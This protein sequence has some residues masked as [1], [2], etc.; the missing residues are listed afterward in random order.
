VSSFPDDSILCR[1]VVMVGVDGVT[2][3]T[4][5][6]DLIIDEPLWPSKARRTSGVE[7]GKFATTCIGVLRA[8]QTCD[9]FSV[10]ESMRKAVVAG[11]LYFFQHTD[12]A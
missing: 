10:G 4:S 1:F 9:R 11:G 2:P 5:G 12:S 7:P 3:T 8:G 6:S